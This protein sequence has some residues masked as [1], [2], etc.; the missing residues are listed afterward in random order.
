MK[1]GAGSGKRAEAGSGKREAGT[2]FGGV[3]VR[4][5]R[6][7]AALLGGSLDLLRPREQRRGLVLLTKTGVGAGEL[8]VQ[9]AVVVAGEL[10]LDQRNRLGEIALLQVRAAERKARHRVG[11]FELGGALKDGQRLVDP[12][13]LQQ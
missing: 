11:R 3:I 4:L 8:D 12:L 7:R 13:Q 5:S 10:R 1:L 2:Y 9:A 6:R